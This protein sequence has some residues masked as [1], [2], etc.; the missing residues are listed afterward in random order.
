MPVRR[1]LLASFDL[2]AQLRDNIEP[3]T[4]S[5]TALVIGLA[6]ALWAALGV[7]SRSRGPLT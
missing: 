5:T 7:T 1:R 6:G 4:G 3:L 2:G